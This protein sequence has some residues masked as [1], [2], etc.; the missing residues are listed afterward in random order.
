MDPT[1]HGTMSRPG[2]SNGSSLECFSICQV[3]CLILVILA[4][5]PGLTFACNACSCIAA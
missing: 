4:V 2:S 5:G 1:Q 3:N